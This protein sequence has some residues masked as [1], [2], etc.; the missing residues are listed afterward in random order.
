M[1]LHEWEMDKY[2][3]SDEIMMIELLGPLSGSVFGID[4]KKLYKERY[5]RN[6]NKKEFR[7]L[8][9]VVVNAEDNLS[10]EESY[11][12]IIGRLFQK[13]GLNKPRRAYSSSDIGFFIGPRV[14]VFH[15]FCRDFT[16]EILLLDSL[17]LNFFFTRFNTRYFQDGKVTMFGEYG[18]AT[19]NI[20]VGEF[21]DR[22]T[23][24]YNVICAWKL[25][26]IIDFQNGLFLLDGTEGIM[27]CPAWES[28]S[29]NQYVK[30]I[31]NGDKIVPVISTADILVRHVEIELL[32]KRDMIDEKSI[33][34]MILRDKLISPDKKYFRY[35]G[36]PDINKI[37][38][39][40]SNC[41]S[42]GEVKGHVRHP[43]IFISAGDIIGQSSIVEHS[44]LMHKILD[45][46]SS[47]HAG[48]RF[49]DPKRDRYL[50]G[51]QGTDYFYTLND[52]ARQQLQAL[53]ACGLNVKELK[54]E[55]V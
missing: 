29:N 36:N 53:I 26:E 31:F 8:I 48:V 7:A 42:L 14:D 52:A 49:Y 22:I 24:Y 16:H 1:M 10:F 54:L 27:P 33:E 4:S 51:S 41:L 9:G 30:I 2:R 47:L 15:E 39:I 43:I 50:I 21:I 28:L 17:K 25:S 44:P 34:E 35:I 23:N 55:V 12:E 38:P 5:D 46:A 45:M 40:R 11:D 6:G 19:K 3:I 37:K 32:K 18:T 20:S 13:Y